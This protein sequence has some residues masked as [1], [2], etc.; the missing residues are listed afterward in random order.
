NPGLS[1]DLPPYFMRA[2]GQGHVLFS[3]SDGKPRD[4]RFTVT[5]TQFMRRIIAVN[6]HDFDSFLAQLIERSCAHG[7]KTDDGDI[8][9]WQRKTHLRK[10]VRIQKKPKKISGLLLI[11]THLRVYMLPLETT[12]TFQGVFA[13]LIKFF[14]NFEKIIL[15]LFDTSEA[16]EILNCKKCQGR[17]KNCYQGPHHR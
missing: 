3:L 1:F 5:R 2:L 9:F 7:S 13:M 4:P 6:S 15:G 16:L 10:I 14:L 17:C 8:V 11:L 12:L